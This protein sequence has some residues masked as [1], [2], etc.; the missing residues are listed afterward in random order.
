MKNKGAASLLFVHKNQPSNL[1]SMP[2]S[3]KSAERSSGRESPG[4]EEP[5]FDDEDVADAEPE[6]RPAKISRATGA[7]GV[8]KKKKKKPTTTKTVKKKLPEPEVEPVVITTKAMAPRK[9]ARKKEEE[10]EPEP[11]VEEEDDAP[12]EETADAGGDYTAA[13]VAIKE[14]RGKKRK[15]PTREELSELLQCGEDTATGF[16][17]KF[18][19]KQDARTNA[20]KAKRVL[21]YSNLAMAMGMGM[22][23]DGADDA[24]ALCE[25]HDAK[26]AA[27]SMADCVRLARCTPLTPDAPSFEKEEFAMRTELSETTLPESA[28]REVQANADAVFKHVICEVVRFTMQQKGIQ[29]I[30]ASVLKATLS[31]YTPYMMFSSINTPPGLVAWGKELG[32]L[33]E[34]END[35]EKM[36][37]NKK[38]VSANVKFA[39]THLMQVTKAKE[40]AKA[41]RE[42]AKTARLTSEDV[43]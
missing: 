42:A 28:A 25:G 22:K 24:M 19:A 36:R 15:L 39:R 3:K 32:I 18:K 40:A 35:K 31:K 12:E 2:P 11:V 23:G 38:T 6:V 26:Q 10:P 41:R 7:G 9:K 5:E 17:K 33:E 29:K 16:L 4:A 34:G 8:V 13:S 37:K 1:P 20:R 43:D 21:G 30:K 27:V 14:F